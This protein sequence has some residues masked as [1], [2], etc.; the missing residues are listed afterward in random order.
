MSVT[1]IAIVIALGIIEGITEWLPISSTGHMLLFDKLLALDAS[2]EFKNMFF[3]V[4]QLGAILAVVILY[5]NKLWPVG[6]SSFG[7]KEE[8]QGKFELQGKPES[9]SKLG[10]Q[11]KLTWKK[12]TL[13]LWLK[14]L[15][16]IIPS[17]IV[18]L[19][20]D[21][22]MDE[23]LHTPLVI[24]IALIVYGVLF[25][26]IE[27]WNKTRVPITRSTSDLTFRL[28]FFVGLFQVLS[29][30]PG[31]SRSGAT[32]MGALLLGLDRTTAAEFC[33]FMGIP[34][35]AGA[36]LI[37]LLKFGLNFTGSELII[38]ILGTLTAFLVSLAVIK[39]LM[40]YIKKHDFTVFGI[41]RIVLGVI[42]LAVL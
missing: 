18:G 42:I 41:Y 32:I 17:G 7:D 37:K 15:V 34:T 21:D 31:T 11:G 28:A 10:T 26:I 16:A 40:A 35:M 29:L 30:V 19:L 39:A 13:A 12:D 6:R 38:L 25:I 36:S 23:H 33:F 1:Q 22:W 3:V 20:F 5:W 8:M 4:I 27:R 24:A 14:T 2:A 9:Q